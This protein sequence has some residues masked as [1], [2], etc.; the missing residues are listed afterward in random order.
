MR[1][2]VSSRRNTGANAE[3]S[4]TERQQV[5][6]WESAAL[7]RLLLGMLVLE[8]HRRELMQTTAP[9]QKFVR[10]MRGDVIVDVFDSRGREGIAVV[11]EILGGSFCFAVTDEGDLHEAVELRGIGERAVRRRRIAERAAAEDAEVGES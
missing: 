10:G 1:G 5:F 3:T 4:I 2:D 11:L 9:R 8:K 7:L 6:A